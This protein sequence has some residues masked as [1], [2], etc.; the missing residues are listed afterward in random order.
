MGRAKTKRPGRRGPT[1]SKQRALLSGTLRANSRGAATVETAEGLY[2]IP[3]DR[4]A[5]AMN[6]DQVQIRPLRGTHGALPLGA[7][8]HVSERHVTSFAGT[9]LKDGPLRVVVPLDDR[10]L[11][12]FLVDPADCSPEEL[13]AGDQ[14][15]VGARIVA[16]PTRKAPGI[17][18][19][20]RVIGPEE[21]E[22]AAVEAIIVAYDLPVGFSDEVLA[23]ARALRLDIP[24]ALEDPKRRDIR[25]RFVV[26]VDPADARDFDDALSIEPLPEGGWLLGVH[27]ADVSAYVRPDTALDRAARERATSTY[28]VD[29]VIPMLP[30]EL[31]CDL[32]SLRPQED[33]LAM[34][35]DLRL[36]KDGRVVGSDF[37]PSAIRSKARFAYEEV[38]GLLATRDSQEQVREVAGVNLYGFFKELDQVR[39]LREKLRRERGAIEFVSVEAKVQLDEACRPIGVVVRKSTPATSLVE[40]ALLAANEAVARAVTVAGIPG[41]FRV[42]EA[43]AEDNLVALVPLL[44]EIGCLKGSAKAG[45]IAGDPHAVQAVLDAVRGKPE[46]ELVSSLLL[47][48]MKRAVYA[49]TDDGHYGLGALTYC[50]FTSPIRRYPDL[51]MHRSLKALLNRSMKAGRRRDLA[52]EIPQI[53]KHSSQME[54]VAAAASNES[55][56]AKLA[57][58]MGGFVGQEF[59]G[60][61]VSVQPFGLF[62][63]LRETSA[64]GLLA[65]RDLGPGWWNFDENRSEL[66]SEDE[67]TRYRLGQPIAVK[68]RAT[69]PLRGKIDFALAERGHDDDRETR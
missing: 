40:E 39:R 7:V 60:V 4:T 52:Y 46:E 69:D 31:S 30:E 62:V 33:R 59:E 50:H 28:L 48:A 20:E 3:A 17:A 68:V 43:P 23:E 5:E 22:T 2:Y 19:I 8:T 45:L 47:R 57:E 32:C 21:S 63:R 16:Y 37:Y 56:A 36:D 55:Q 64:E 65:V 54:R 14:V 61:V 66:V 13:G 9:Y 6:G 51:V 42:H 35:V 10:L 58:Y 24:A 27:I 67:Q 38:D 15:L 29:R 25:D 12:D 44:T 18:T 1:R 41:A 26:T 49:P 34:T 11:H 53:C